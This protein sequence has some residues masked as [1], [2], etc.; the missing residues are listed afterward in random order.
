ML[1]SIASCN[2]AVS[3]FLIVEGTEMMKLSEMLAVLARESGTAS[4][5]M[6]RVQGGAQ[7]GLSISCMGR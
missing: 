4:V 7:S 3:P 1:Q 6:L 2:G 5:F